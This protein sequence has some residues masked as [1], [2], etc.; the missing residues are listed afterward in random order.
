M[1]TERIDVVIVGAGQGGLGTAYFLKQAGLD[2]VVL[3]RGE[4]GNT[5]ISERWD[6][7]AL[8]TPN[9]MNGLPGSPYA[10]GDPDGFMPHGELANSFS[11]YAEDHDLP[12]RTGVEVTSVSQNQTGGFEVL[13]ND[14]GS[15]QAIHTRSVVVAAGIAS[16]PRI[17]AASTDVPVDILQLNTTSYR[18]PG[19]TPEGAVVVVGGGQSGAQIVED[20][21]HAGR[22]VYW[23]ISGAPRVPRRYRGRDFMDWWVQMGLWDL[24]PADLDDPSMLGATNPLVSGL[25]PKGHSLSFQ[26]LH[27]LG[28]T[29]LG[30]LTG[31]DGDV[32]H[33]DDA[34]V[35]YINRADVR[36][37]DMRAAID[38]YI[39]AEGLEAPEPEDDPGDS[40][41][42]GHEIEFL[43]E[44]DLRSVGVSTIVWSAGFVPHFPWL[45][46]PVFDETN[47]PIHHN[48]VAEVEGIYFIGFPWVSKRKSGVIY[49]IEEDARHIADTIASRLVDAEA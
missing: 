44:V 26:Y 6:S 37:R 1:T 43:T 29:L 41:F 45:H 39:E 47:H 24:T 4:I 21:L 18:S 23:C 32:L 10:G 46:V 38:A 33:T 30:R 20:L 12:V 25:G 13:A 35:E 42:V 5:W 40:E 16:H 22:V 2:F 34:V 7:F 15:E 11:R 9:W 19:A 48:G 3:E 14:D 28:A 36:S 17:P 49:G 31:I 8:N 27:G